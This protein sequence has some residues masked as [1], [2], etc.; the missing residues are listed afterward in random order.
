M[1]AF[2]T[3]VFVYAEGANDTWRRDR[4]LAVLES[5]PRASTVVPVQVLGELYA[6]LTR[7]F[8]HPPAAARA[9]VLQWQATSNVRDTTATALVAALDLAVEHGFSP[10]DAVITSVAGEAGCRVLLS[11]D[12]HHGF[13]WRGLTIV[14][15]FTRQLDPLLT[16]LVPSLG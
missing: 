7:K 1:I 12:L 13:T 14:N 9:A 5:L 6:V 15:P 2:D 8:R 11:E 16:E 3:N 10:W 4:A